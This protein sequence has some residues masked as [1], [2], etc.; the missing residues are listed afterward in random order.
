MY[1]CTSCKILHKIKPDYDSCSYCNNKTVIKLKNKNNIKITDININFKSNDISINFIDPVI[2]QS[3]NSYN[4][5]YPIYVYGRENTA[6]I[7]NNM[8]PL[9]LLI[10][11]LELF[12]TF[13]SSNLELFFMKYYGKKDYLYNITFY[14]IAKTSLYDYDIVVPMTLISIINWFKETN[15]NNYSLIYNKTTWSLMKVNESQTNIIKTLLQENAIDNTQLLYNGVIGYRFGRLSF[16][17][18]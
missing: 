12:K 4:N 9:G 13:D 3:T 5:T 6:E 16:L 7:A 2:I 14:V 18:Q 10:D 17:K 8:R 11:N 15:H 1:F